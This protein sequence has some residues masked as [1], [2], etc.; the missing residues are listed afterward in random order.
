MKGQIKCYIYINGILF[1]FK[2]EQSPVICN[3]DKSGGHFTK[4]NKLVTE[5]QI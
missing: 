1:G 3:K 2:K 4:W 5:G